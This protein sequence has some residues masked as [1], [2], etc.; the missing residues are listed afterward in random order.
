MSPNTIDT[1]GTPALLYAARTRHADIVRLLLEQD[2]NANAKDTEED[3][4]TLM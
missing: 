2:A 1:K 3:R 4:T